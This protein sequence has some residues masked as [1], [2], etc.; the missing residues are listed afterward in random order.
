MDLFRL[1]VDVDG[2]VLDKSKVA[3]DDVTP[4]MQAPFLGPFNGGSGSAEVPIGEG[5]HAILSWEGTPEGTAR[6]DFGVDDDGYLETVLVSGRDPA[7]DAA[8]LARAGKEWGEDAPGVAIFGELR[9]IDQRPLLVGRE[10][11][12]GWPAQLAGADVILA[13]VFLAGL[14]DLS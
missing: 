8:A 14:P 7:A 2:N 4:A 6:G 13:A 5:K 12:P 3:L 1:I 11:A 9:G 10:L